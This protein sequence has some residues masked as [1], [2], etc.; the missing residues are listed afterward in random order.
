[1]SVWRLLQLETHDASMNMAIDEAVLRA[2]IKNTAPNTLRF[3]R[4]KP[5]AVSIG[6]FQTLKNEVHVESCKEK[7]VDT[8]R[9]ITG[10][11]AVYHDSEDEITYS[12]IARKED[13][14]GADIAAVYERIYAGLVEALRILGVTADFDKGNEK[15]CPNLTVNGKKISGSAQSHKGVVVLQHGTLLVRVNFERMFTFLRPPAARTCIEILDIARDKITSVSGELKRDVSLEEV[16]RA[17]TQ[18]FRRAL[19]IKL[20]D[21]KLTTD[22]LQV[23]REL[24]R[25]KYATNDWNSQGRSSCC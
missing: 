1:L 16:T 2:R 11:G 3:Y 21:G 22:E 10:G 18:G 20:V 7:G 6:K 5:S 13:L 25:E 9:R 4:W 24:A 23:A 15:V 12:V 17:L 14:Q 8:I 19:S